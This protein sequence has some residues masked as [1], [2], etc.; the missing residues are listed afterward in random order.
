[1]RR[2]SFVLLACLALSACTEE[3]SGPEP[4]MSDMPEELSTDPSFACNEDE[5]TWI[6]LEGEDFSPLVFDAIAREDDHDVELPTVTLTLRY[7]ETGEPVDESFSVTLDSPPQMDDGSVR[8]LDDETMQFL[9]SEELEL[10][11]GVYDVRV[12]NPN[13]TE[14]TDEEAFGVIDR[15]SLHTAIPELTCVA[16][17]ARDIVLEG[18]NLMVDADG[19]VPT[20]R[21]DDEE[22]EVVEM[23]D[24]RELHPV[25]V[26]HQLCEQVTVR[27]E[28]GS[29]D[30][31]VYDVTAANFD[32]AGCMSDADEDE[33]TVTVNDPPQPEAIAPTP[34]C[35]EQL[36][37]EAMEIEGTGFVVVRD[38]NGEEVYPTVDV[39]DQNYEAIAA[40][41]CEDI[42]SAP[43]LA[44]ERCGQITIAIEADDLADQVGAGETYADLAIVVTNPEP[45]GCH[46][47]DELDLTAVPPPTVDEVAPDPMCTAQFENTLTVT[48]HGYL[49]IGD[50][51]PVVHVGDETYEVE[52]MEDCTDVPTPET[53]TVSCETLTITVP[54]GDLDTERTDVSVENPETAACESTDDST[55]QVVPPPTVVDLQP[56]PLCVEQE[57][58]TLEIDGE[59]FL[60]IDGELPSVSIGGEDF[61]ATELDDC[62]EL[63]VD[64]ETRD[65]RRCSTLFVDVEA[66]VLDADIHDVIVTNPEGANCH[67]QEDLSVETVAPPQITSVAPRAVCSIDESATFDVEGE[68]L[69]EVDGTAPQIMLDGESYDTTASNCSDVDDETRLCSNLEFSVDPREL[70]DDL[71]ELV[72]V[73]P[74]AV[75]CESDPSEPIA[76][77][78]PPAIV[79]TEPAGG[80][81]GETMDAQMTLFGQF[82]RDPEG[83]QPIVTMDGDPVSID[84]FGDCDAIDLG[85]FTLETCHEIDV[86]VPE[87]LREQAFEITVTGGDPVAC[88]E[89][90]IPIE[91]EP[92]PVVTAVIPERICDAG[93]TLTIEGE[94]LSPDAE[95]YLDGVAAVSVDVA[96]DQQS[97]TAT[98]DGPLTSEYKT[99]EVVNP[100]GCSST[101]EFEVRVTEGPRPIFVDP[102]VT[103]DGMNTQV[104]IYATGLRG[105]SID[106]VELLHPDGSISVLDH[107][108][109]DDRENIVQAVIPEGTLD[110]GAESDE[111]GIRLTD[112]IDDQNFCTNETD[113]VL[114]ITSELTVAVESIDPPF[115]GQDESTGVE[116]F[117]EEEPDGDMVQF[118]AVP[119]AY[120]NPTFGDEDSVAREIRSVQFIDETELA[121]IIPSGLPVGVYDVI[122]VNPDGAIGVLDEAFDITAEPPPLIDSVSP[123]SWETG[124]VVQ[125]DIEGENFRDD[126]EDPT[127]EVFCRAADDDTTEEDQLSNPAGITIDE[128]DDELVEMTVDTGGLDHLD[129]CYLRLTNSN[130][131]YAEYSPITVTNPASNFVSFQE[132]TELNQARHAPTTF[133]GVP[134]RAARYLYVVGGD[135][136][137]LSDAFTSGEYARVDR[138]GSP[139]TWRELPYH[140]PAGRTLANGERIDDFVYLV[141]G[142]DAG[143]DAVSDEVHR[144]RV[145]DPLD[146]PEIVNVDLFFEP[147]G[148][149]MDVGTYYYRVAAVYTSGDPANP[150]GE[151]LA[152]EPQPIQ[153]PVDDLH[154][155][156]SWSPPEDINHQIDHYRV[157]RSVEPDDP[158]GE[159]SLIYETADADET[160][161][162]DNGA[163]TPTSGENPLPTGSLGTWHHVATLEHP[164]MAAGITAAVNPEDDD[165][166]FIYAIGG[167]DD[168]GDYRAD[169]EFI[170]VGV[171]GPRAQ[172]VGDDATP[173]ELSPGVPNLLIGERA[174]LQAVTAHSGNASSLSGVDPQVFVVGGESD[175]IDSDAD[176]YVSTVTAN[177]QLEEW[178]QLPTQQRINPARQG[179]AAA[180]LNNNVVLAGGEEDDAEDS[181][182]DAEIECEGDCPPASLDTA[183]ASQGGVGMRARSWMGHVTFRGFWY[184]TGGLDG[185]GEPTNTVDY[186][187]AGGTP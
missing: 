40:D 28:E 135:D 36:G 107:S 131:T 12:E 31:G 102:P 58:R 156:I 43:G 86:T 167:E 5:G 84:G 124:E 24:C 179:H 9:V 41:G 92:E 6:T 68:N 60:D 163:T 73:N 132:G 42:E 22:V 20:V 147:E 144:A 101:D 70:S 173:G 186:S 182:F 89:D 19:E 88:G 149:T 141:G 126:P 166:Y 180:A 4:Q 83:D 177:G 178:T 11:E 185:N 14:V 100:G 119:R 139:G 159:E 91:R 110:D 90:S 120:L 134:S 21:L 168:E 114:T 152:S 109:D 104:T 34:I 74:E 95:V 69:Y 54:E 118:E 35:S 57:T 169:Y 143:E 164:R 44:A 7:D 78:N 33:V 133:S 97:A 127:V 165:E 105:G 37:Y 64:D 18:Q 142:Y 115:G 72:A 122:V 46:S 184:L 71:H 47:T 148:P 81:E 65:V 150:G 15:P 76:M 146:V 112:Q 153:V 96:G 3:I 160:S 29:F 128:V 1:M 38:D 174:N 136:E 8:W 99:L 121:G 145:L 53:T 130:E 113:E 162:L 123:G 51:E 63:P 52:T 85:D 67:S 10:P 30:A 16:Q 2:L 23:A 137:G 66:D 175:G 111:F 59:E 172:Q 17:G 117:A 103:F 56:Q 170:T 93:G 75:G 25:F 39:G 45:V 48:G 49:A 27:L 87:S 55:V 129:V 187:P 13:G 158:Y 171:E 157:Y 125:V 106:Q 80:C 154:V 181:V 155:S 138:F 161:F 108:V 94:N 151:S 176:V 61:D 26:G 77:T 82:D 98:F 140:L 79:F 116:I 62:D 32:P 183:A 50:G